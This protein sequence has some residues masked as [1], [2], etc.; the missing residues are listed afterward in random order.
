MA[1]GILSER[2]FKT[3]EF[4]VQVVVGDND[5]LGLNFV[6]IFKFGYRL[7]AFIYVCLGFGQDQNIPAELCFCLERIEFFVKF[8]VVRLQFL[9]KIIHEHKTEV[10]SGVLVF[11]VGITDTD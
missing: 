9:G 1:A 6:E 2:V 4:Y 11:L 10:V 3:S 7:P 8:K 5:I